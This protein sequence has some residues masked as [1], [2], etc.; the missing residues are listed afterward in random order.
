MFEDASA[1]NQDLS[2]WDVSSGINCVSND[3]GIQFVSIHSLVWRFFQVGSSVKSISDVWPV[4]E[5]VPST[6][7]CF[8]L[9][10]GVSLTCFMGPLPSIK[11]SEAGMLASVPTL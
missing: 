6:K 1:F 9:F 3:Q 8:P 7:S 11:T 2:N 5:Q 10:S 4:K